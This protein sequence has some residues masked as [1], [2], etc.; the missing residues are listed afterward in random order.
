MTID[1]PDAGRR[2]VKSLLR[3]LVGGRAYGA[4]HGAAKAWDI[5]TGRW[6]EPELAVVPHL[7]R[8]GETAI[9]VGANFGLWTYHLSRVVGP[10]GRV[11]AI[12]PVPFAVGALRRVVQLLRLGNVEILDRGLSDSPG[13]VTFVLPLQESGAINAG[14]AHIGGRDD[15]RAGAAEH[16][17]S[18]GRREVVCEVVRLDDVGVTGDVAFLKCDIEGAELA[19]LRG[20]ERLLREHAPTLL[21]EV[22]PWFLEGYGLAPADVFAFLAGLGYGPPRRLVDGCLRA[23]SGAEAT[24]N[25]LVAHPRRADRLAP[26]QG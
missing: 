16:V 5:R 25:L 14:L 13:S 1:K 2:R 12:E 22:D 24:G 21:L 18:A 17:P 3:P 6:S 15:A 23:V 7:L 10:S 8:P 4:L 19:A 20:G 9:D 26:L 11:W